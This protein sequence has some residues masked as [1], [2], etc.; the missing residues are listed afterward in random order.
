VSPETKKPLVPM[1]STH[2]EVPDFIDEVAGLPVGRRR[3]IAGAGAVAGAATMASFLPAG[4]ANA[5]LPAGASNFHILPKA[6]RL[7]DTRE[8]HNYPFTATLAANQHIRVQ[9]GGANGVPASASAAVLT[10]TAVNFGAPS[11]VTVWPTG[12]PLPLASNLNLAPGAVTANLVTVKLGGGGLIDVISHA[13]G[14]LIVDVLGYYEPVSG[15]VKEGRYVTLNSSQRVYDSRPAMP[16]NE[17]YTVIDVTAS[18]PADASAVVLNLTAAGS[19]AGGHFTA[20]PIDAPGPPSTSSLNVSG[21]GENRAAGV[22]VPVQTINGKRQI[23]VYAY[24]AAFI[25]VDVFGYYTGPGSSSS[26][27]GLFVPVTPV[28]LKDTRLPGEIGKMWP[29]WVVEVPIPA[30]I[31]GQA[32]AVAVNVTGVDSRAAGHLTV[33]PSRRPIPNTSNVNWA[34]SGAVVPNHVIC[35]VTKSFG[36]QVYNAF[37]SHV[38]VDLAGY[39]L[40]SPQDPVLPPYQNPPPP[41]AGPTWIMRIPRLGLT[42]QVISG[43]AS[44]VD[45]IDPVSGRGYTWHWTGTGYMGQSAHVAVFGHRTDANGP[46]RQLHTMV[47]GDRLTVTT[48]DGREFTYE[49]VR[50]DLTDSNNTNILNATRA[51]PGNTLSIVAC[52]LLN[53]LPTSLSYRLVVTFQ[54]VSWR[55]V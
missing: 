42:T 38:I 16:G 34:T 53:Y 21:P 22:V 36:L 8:S 6:V 49:M 28:R 54:L 43:A 29:G 51:H 44:V 12:E 26:D 20:M 4:A 19:T 7:A 45:R 9:V 46:Y 25:I 55:E 18:V 30:S 50:R 15:A 2:P 52:T 35:Q 27:R 13:L 11:H 31:D 23:K 1:N 10:V 17:S 3:L 40:G 41:P 33:S 47:G 39:F 48:G 37:G 32:A 14:H 24:R 5:A